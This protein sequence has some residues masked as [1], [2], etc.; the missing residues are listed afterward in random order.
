MLSRLMNYILLGLA[1][2]GVYF[3]LSNH[4]I[5][6]GVT[7]F[8]LLKK[9]ELNFNYTFY[10]IRQVPPETALKITVLRE[11]GLGDLMVAKGILSQERL[12]EILRKH[13]D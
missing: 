3:L 1:G 2:A 10:S 11:N 5:F 9:S 7:E 12:N 13:Y 8:D 6:S 4:I